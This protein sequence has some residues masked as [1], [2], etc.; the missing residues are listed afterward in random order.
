MDR[1]RPL[2][3]SGV[4]QLADPIGGTSGLE[5]LEHSVPKV[6]LDEGG[7]LFDS[8]P[9]VHPEGA[10]DVRSGSRDHG[11]DDGSLLKLQPEADRVLPEEGEAI[12]VGAV[13]SAAP[14]FLTG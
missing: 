3:H 5:P 8:C 7:K 11:V 10:R 9:G 2:E 14:W 1:L 12:V 6:H 4:A 13:G